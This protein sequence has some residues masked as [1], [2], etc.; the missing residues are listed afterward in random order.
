MAFGTRADLADAITGWL[1][2]SDLALR[3]PD[4]IRLAEVRMN[5]LL[6]DPDQIVTTPLAFTAGSASLPADFG[7]MI[8]L[9]GEGERLTQVTPGEFGSYRSEA[10]TA[11][12]YAVSGDGINILPTMASASIPITYYRAIEPLVSDAS[13]NWLLDRAPD[14]YLYGSLLQAEFYGWNDERLGTIK[15]A[16]DEGVAELR[17]DGE[18]RRWG[19]APLAPKIRRS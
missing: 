1:N 7:Q 10:G 9:G 5:R 4:F 2:R 16:W 6:R 19:A 13:T 11:T 12:V 8:A 3:I 18:N 14:L 17:I 15:T